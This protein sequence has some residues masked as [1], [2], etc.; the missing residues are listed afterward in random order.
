MAIVKVRDRGLRNQL[1]KKGFT[2]AGS[3]GDGISRPVEFTLAGDPKLLSNRE[4]PYVYIVGKLHK[5]GDSYY[6]K[7]KQVGQYEVSQS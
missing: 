3:I 2:E 4:K 7:T 6:G 5:K 1:V